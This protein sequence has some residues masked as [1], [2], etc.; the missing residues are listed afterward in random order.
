MR[1]HYID[2]LRNLAILYLFPYHTAR[3][4]DAAEPYYVQGEPSAVTTGLINISYWF[5]PL[6]FLLAGMAS[7]FG[8]RKRSRGQYAEERARRLLIPLV[9]GV[10]VLVPPQAYI[11]Q[12]FHTGS[13]PAY[14]EFL[15]RY[16]TDW[17]DLS[18]YFGTFTPGQ[19]WFIAFLL[20]ISLALL[21]V[22]SAL[23]RRGYQARWLRRPTVLFAAPA[24]GLL[25]LSAL[26]AL[27]G[28][29]LFLYAGFFFAGY[30]LAGDEGTLH[31]IVRMR[32][33][34][35]AIAVAGAIAVL[36]EHATIGWQTGFTP[37]GILFSAWHHLVCWA[38]LLAI[39]GY[40]RRRLNRPSRVMGYLNKAA[41]PVFVLHQTVL[42]AVGL[43]VLAL[44]DGTPMQY[45]LTV[46]GSA[47]ITFALY[48]GMRRVPPLRFLL[49][50]KAAG[51]GRRVTGAPAS[52]VVDD[53]HPEPHGRR[54]R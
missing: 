40:G 31:V 4:F 30:L 29:N 20:V 28:K 35:L 22:M 54:G 7:F 5:M 26:P 13:V 45:W 52:R 16:F 17:S 21:P 43:V 38:A 18:G 42:V 14:P 46:V 1:H 27:S 8:L 48:E 3:M 49:G 36:V 39:L 24:L 33:L 6:L 10:L 9:F 53:S 41:F 44:V 19:L 37:I 51:S 2:W 47:A 32:R 11:A 23:S 25:A 34:A 12:L 50:I 15:A